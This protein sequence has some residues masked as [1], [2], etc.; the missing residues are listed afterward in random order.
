MKVR[1]RTTARVGDGSVAQ[2]IT[3]GGRKDRQRTTTGIVDERTTQR[4]N[5][6]CVGALV[7]ENCQEWWC[8]VYPQRIRE[9]I[10]FF[11]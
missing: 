10:P 2:R 8:D 1:Q 3:G 6:G 5:C 11:Y 4:I 7:D 9:V